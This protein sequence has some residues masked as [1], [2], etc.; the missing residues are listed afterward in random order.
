M[1]SSP[2][3]NDLLVETLVD[4]IR[5]Q[6]LDE[7][8]SI[9]DAVEDLTALRTA[10]TGIVKSL[11]RDH[12]DVANM[13]VAGQ[14]GVAYCL[15]RAT[16][17]PDE[18]TARELK[19]LGKAIAYNSAA[20]CWPG[21]GDPG[22][23]VEAAHVSAGLA[24][25]VES[26]DLVLALDLGP[27]ELGTADWLVGALEFA[28]GRADA[29]RQAFEQAERLFAEADRTRQALMAR[30]YAGLARKVDPQLHAEGER[31]LGEAVTQLKADGSKEALF[32][33]DQLATAER[34]LISR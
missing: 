28:A 31:M 12:H 10:L 24:L 11:Y 16:D 25:A 3:N 18:A 8:F 7:A 1:T 9:V 13:V 19:R 22:I 21:W 15:R 20:N 5:D 34:L 14:A 32:F 17:A 29:A 27:V 4:L 26:R 33:V 6:R 23:T 2:H 30:G